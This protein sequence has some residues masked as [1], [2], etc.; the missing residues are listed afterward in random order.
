MR[1]AC[2]PTSNAYKPPCFATAVRGHQARPTRMPHHRYRG[3]T[4]HGSLGRLAAGGLHPPRVLMRSL[5]SS[6]LPWHAAEYG[7]P[8]RCWSRRPCGSGNRRSFGCYGNPGRSGRRHARLHGLAK[9]AAR[10][11][12]LWE[13]APACSPQNARCTVLGS[14]LRHRPL[15]WPA[16][17]ARLTV[18]VSRSSTN[19]G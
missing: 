8:G 13:R 7:W 17:P 10:A 2:W 12:R 5:S 14:N 9:V 4:Q 16:L 15:N 6:R 11:C 3:P 19:L 1:S 18:P